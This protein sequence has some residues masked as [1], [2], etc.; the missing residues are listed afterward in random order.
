MPLPIANMKGARPFPPRISMFTAPFWDG[1][2]EG[3]FLTTKCTHCE[4]LTFPPKPICPY[5]WSSK[6]EWQS[7]SGRG[8]LYSRTTIHA[9]PKVFA[10]E[11][12]YQVAIIDLEENLRIATR[13]SGDVALDTPV[14]LTVLKYDDGCLFE[15]RAVIDD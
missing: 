4:K 1:L 13:I 3:Q 10:A 6:V 2:E 5:C 14:A 12:P 8:R 9:A 15:A 7:L 11:A